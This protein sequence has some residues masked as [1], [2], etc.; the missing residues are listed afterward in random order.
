MG[1]SV[2]TRTLDEFDDAIADGNAAALTIADRDLLVIPPAAIARALHLRDL[3]LNGT[4]L[5]AL[6]TSFGCLVL[7]ERLSLDR[8]DLQTLPLSFHELKNLTSL[9]LGN[10]QLQGLMGNFCDLVALKHLW[11]HNNELLKLPQEFGNLQNLVFLDLHG[12]KLQKLPKSICCLEKLQ[13]L[14]LS[15]NKLKSLPAAFSNLAALRVCNIS[16][17]ILRDLPEHFG[18]L[19]ALE[20]LYAQHNCLMTLP[21]SFGTLAATLHNLALGNNKM[22]VF[23]QETFRKLSN[24]RSLTLTENRLKHWSAD[25]AVKY[26]KNEVHDDDADADEEAKDSGIN[27]LFGLNALEYVDFSDNVLRKLPSHGWHQLYHLVDLKLSHNKLTQLPAAMGKL[28][29]LRQLDVSHNT[30]V[31]LPPS[32]M[33]LKKLVQLNLHNNSLT[34]IPENVDECSALERL[35]ISKNSSL[36]TLPPRL[37]KLPNIKWLQMDKKCFLGLEG[38]LMAFCE[39]LETFITD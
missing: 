30:L 23:P 2:S 8:N 21:P 31:S 32:L 20:T 17:N 5:G 27:G 4:R 24:L 11:L 6:P 35:L 39:G 19:L 33:Q 3:A 37:C 18:A 36:P 25:D 9:H 16:R 34:A 7:L 29:A 13:R 15:S 10:N 28:S 22:D 38:E 12:N 14:N 1:G 26:S